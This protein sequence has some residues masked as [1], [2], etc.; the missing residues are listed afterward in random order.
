MVGVSVFDLKVSKNSR[1]KKLK[2]RVGAE[3]W[4]VTNISAL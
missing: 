2:E 1:L 4:G 3:R